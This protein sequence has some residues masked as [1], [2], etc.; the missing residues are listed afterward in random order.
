[1]VASKPSDQQ[2]FYVLQDRSAFESKVGAGEAL[3]GAILYRVEL[4]GLRLAGANL[5][6]A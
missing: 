2:P 1:M 5:D 3:I 4:R 6:G